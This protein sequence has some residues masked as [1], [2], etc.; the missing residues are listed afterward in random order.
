MTDGLNSVQRVSDDIWGAVVRN[1]PIPSVDLIVRTNG[2][3][4]L[5]R[6]Q[7]EP[8]KGEWFVPGGRVQKG[9]KLT[10]TVMR[11]AKIELGVKVN[12][13]QQLGAYDH[14]YAES[15]IPKSGGKHY[16]AHGYVVSPESESFELD[17]QHD[18]VRVFTE[19]NLPELHKYV[20]KYID[21]VEFL[22]N[23]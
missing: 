18:Q 21:D 20:K 9:E 23:T 6:R 8:A 4:L 17:S 14:L 22:D 10:D 3:I 1:V 11:V 2:G 16:V 13:E 12:I 19:D 5:A 7:N 15:D